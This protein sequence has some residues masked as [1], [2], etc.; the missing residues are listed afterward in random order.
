M[1]DAALLRDGQGKALLEGNLNNSRD[2]SAVNAFCYR[3]Y[4]PL[5]TR[6]L[7]RGMDPDATT[8]MLKIGRIVFSRFCFG[9]PTR[10][11]EFDPTSGNIIVVNTL[12]GSVRH[13]LMGNQAFDTRAGDSYVVDCSRTEYW[14]I[15]DGND[16]QLNLT[17]PHSLMEEIASRWYGFVPGD[18]LWKKRL[19]FG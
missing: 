3:T 18:E 6:P 19:I 11:D 10:A 5:A 7:T 16:L 4:M 8:R 1:L 2:W 14:N 17:I 15:A 12:R 9:T 13:P